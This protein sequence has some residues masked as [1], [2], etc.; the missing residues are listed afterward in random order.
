MQ[1]DHWRGCLATST[2]RAGDKQGAAN[3][4]YRARPKNMLSIGLVLSLLLIVLAACGG[5]GGSTSQNGQ[6]VHLTYALWDANQQPTYQKSI[7]QFEQLHPNIK[8]TI[9]QN[10]W[11]QYWQKLGTEFLPVLSPGVLLNSDLD[12]RMELLELIDGFLIRGL[13]VRVP[14][15]VGQMNDLPVLRRRAA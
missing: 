12:I 11:T 6:V 7:D 5:S 8:V 15:S 3:Q 1:L 14:E 10:P 2:H 4:S 9:E 13:L